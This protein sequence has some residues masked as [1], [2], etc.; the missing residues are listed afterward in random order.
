MRM[1]YLYTREMLFV[2]NNYQQ[3]YGEF[4]AAKYVTRYPATSC[5]SAKSRLGDG[6][7]F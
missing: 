2:L 3:K 1:N 6:N 5:C 7:A 4:V